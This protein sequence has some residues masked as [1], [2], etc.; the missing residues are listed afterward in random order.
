MQIKLVILTICASLAAIGY[1]TPSPQ[2]DPNA[3]ELDIS[4]PNDEQTTPG[5]DDLGLI[6]GPDESTEVTALDNLDDESTNALVRRI[7]FRG[8]R[9][10]GRRG[11]RRG[12]RRRKLLKYLKKK[13]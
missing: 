11:R 4:I 9:R 13:E 5:I 1:A 10:G 12:G 2:G 3:D 7:F 6:G 8:R